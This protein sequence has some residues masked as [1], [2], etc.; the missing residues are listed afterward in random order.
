MWSSGLSMMK[1]RLRLACRSWMRKACMAC[2]FVR[3]IPRTRTSSVSSL[4][5]SF[6]RCAASVPLALLLPLPA[7]ATDSAVAA[8]GA[9]PTAAALPQAAEEGGVDDAPLSL[10]IHVDTASPPVLRALPWS[11]QSEPSSARASCGLEPP[12]AGR[13]RCGRGVDGLRGTRLRG[14]TWGPRALPMPVAPATDRGGR[15][16]GEGHPDEVGG[17]DGAGAA[18]R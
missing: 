18:A 14:G 10:T 12:P 11:V 5:F 8:A 4:S 16:E 15:R 3:F 7:A 17:C 13:A 9:A 1:T 2:S 6:S